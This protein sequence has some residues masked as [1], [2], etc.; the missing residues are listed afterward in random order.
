MTKTCLKTIKPNRKK[1]LFLAKKQL[2]ELV[3]DAVN[4]EGVNFTLPEIQTLLDG[5]TVGGH[6]LQDE[7][8][9]LNQANAWRFLFDCVEQDRFALSKDFVCD[10]HGILAQKEALTWG[11]FR[12]GGVTIA[13]T[14]HIPPRADKLPTLWQQLTGKHHPALLQSEMRQ[15]KIDIE[16]T[17][18]CAISL[19]LQM[20]RIQFFYDANKRLGRLMMNGIL[21]VNGLPAINLPAKK[22]LEFNQLML[23]FYASDDEQPMQIF[24]RACLERKI[25]EIMSE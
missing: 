21:L 17:Y 18:T 3:C 6:S 19:F 10:L 15:S 16:Q 4:L 11:V 25:L 8:I 1:A 22:Q 5:I 23:D 14:N 20:A 9:A 2:P 13:G 24:M 12:N 7:T